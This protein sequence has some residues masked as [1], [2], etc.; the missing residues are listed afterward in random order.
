MLSHIGFVQGGFECITL[1]AIF[2]VEGLS[3]DD[4]IFKEKLAQAAA[5]ASNY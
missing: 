1:Q 3:V 4:D 5:E 2:E